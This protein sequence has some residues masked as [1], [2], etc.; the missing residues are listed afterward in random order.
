MQ[1]AKLCTILIRLTLFT[2]L[3][4]VTLPDTQ[5]KL[6]TLG[7]TRLTKQFIHILLDLWQMVTPVP[8]V[9]LI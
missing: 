1:S 9:Y 2:T 8:K 6:D 3:T 7:V 4:K 5:D